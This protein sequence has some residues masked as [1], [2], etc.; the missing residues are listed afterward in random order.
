MKILFP[1]S[2]T[3]CCGLVG[4]FVCFQENLTGGGNTLLNTP[5][6]KIVKQT[7]TIPAVSLNGNEA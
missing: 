5:D 7:A 3:G 1:L 2:G 6:H 4:Y